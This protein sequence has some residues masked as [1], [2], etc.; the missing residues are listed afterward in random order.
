MCASE[1][2]NDNDI[3]LFADNDE[4]SA[5]LFAIWYLHLINPAATAVYLSAAGKLAAAKM[6]A[7]CWCFFQLFALTY[8]SIFLVMRVGKF[9]M[10]CP[11]HHRDIRDDSPAPELLVKK[12]SRAET[13]LSG[14]KESHRPTSKEDFIIIR[15]IVSISLSKNNQTQKVFC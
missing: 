10:C 15:Q 7:R 3:L 11:H 13:L 9:L 8:G 1:A 2:A 14:E 12:S 5:V 6:N 4:T